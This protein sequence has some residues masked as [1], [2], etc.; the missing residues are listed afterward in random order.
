MKYLYSKSDLDITEVWP[1]VPPVTREAPAVEPGVGVGG[2]VEG[3]PPAPSVSPG[4]ANFGGINGSS[5]SSSSDDSRTC[6]DSSNS[7]DS[8][9]LPAH[10]GR[11]ALYLEVFGELPALQS[12]RKR[13][14][15]WGLTM[16]ASCADALQ[17]YAVR[18]VEAK[19]TVE[20]ETAEIERAHDS[21][22]EEH[23]KKA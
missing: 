20:E 22:L 16:S 5:N 8:G 23:L 13:F 9:D 17:A 19:R 7:N 10:V 1:P 12:G 3:N 18:I 2:G 4:W 14:Q 15:S 21:L 6:S 11:P